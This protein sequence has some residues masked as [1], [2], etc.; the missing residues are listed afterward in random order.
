M[1][2]LPTE[3]S[4]RTKRSA[5]LRQLWRAVRGG[6]LLAG[7]NV[8]LEHTP[9]G[10]RVHAKTSRGGGITYRWTKICVDGEEKWA[11][12]ARSVI[13]DELPEGVEEPT[14]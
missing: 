6:R 1:I 12:V 5:W 4:G 3:P 13:Y 14:E 9:E 2:P 10:T 7:E 8:V 11:Q